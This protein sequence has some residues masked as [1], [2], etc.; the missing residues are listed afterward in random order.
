[1][2]ETSEHGKLGGH[3]SCTEEGLKWYQTRSSAI[4]LHETLP[5]YG[6]VIYEKVYMLPRPPP[7]ISWKHEWKRELGSEVAQRLEGQF[8]QQSKGSQSNQLNTSSD[9]DDRT[10]QPVF[11]R[12]ARTAPGGRKTSR[13][14]E[15]ETRSFHEEAA[16]HDRTGTP[17]IGCDRNYEPGSG[18]SMLNEVN[19]DFRILGLPHSV[20]KQ[21]QNSRV[22]ELIK[23][24]ENHP[25]KQMIQVV[26]NVE[27]LELFETDS[28]TQ[29]KACLSYW[30]I[31]ILYCTCRESGG[32]QLRPKPY[33]KYQERQQSAT[34]SSTLL[35]WSGSCWSS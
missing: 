2:E 4:I 5:V 13:F 22:G 29:C 12:D 21:A 18:Q 31:G 30:N 1:M 6:E 35:Q 15:I 23:K 16:Q 9:L 26:G 10:G 25:H 19:I 32:Q 7:K 24:I 14:Q 11:G 28:K 27:L 20:V 33:W 34:S 8:V 17:V 3:P